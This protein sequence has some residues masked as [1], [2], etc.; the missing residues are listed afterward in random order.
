LGAS[1]GA[2]TDEERPFFIYSGDEFVD[3][4]G[5]VVEEFDLKADF[6]QGIGDVHN[7]KGGINITVIA[8]VDQEN[9]AVYIFHLWGERGGADGQFIDWNC[10]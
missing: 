8:I 7:A 3:Y 9:F 10:G 6:L 4:F 1:D 5:R 2:E